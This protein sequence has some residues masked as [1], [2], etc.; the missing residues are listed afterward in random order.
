MS[1]SSKVGYF[2]C[3]FVRVVAPYM[4]VFCVVAVSVL[5]CLGGARQVGAPPLLPSR[6]LS[7]PVFVRGWCVHADTL[8]WY[9][10]YTSA[11]RTRSHVFVFVSRVGVQITSWLA[12]NIN[13]ANRSTRRNRGF[14]VWRRGAGGDSWLWKPCCRVRPGRTEVLK[15]SESWYKAYTYMSPRP[16]PRNPPC[17]THP[18][19]ALSITRRLRTPKPPL[20]KKFRVNSVHAAGGMVIAS[21]GLV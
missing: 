8:P 21:L 15:P 18:H 10:I 14:C 3:V 13:T 17:P 9:D 7:S 6:P 11:W 16:S 19:C 1:T 2:L 5:A 20:E 12:H 4:Y